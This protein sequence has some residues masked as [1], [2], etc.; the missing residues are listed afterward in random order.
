VHEPFGAHPSP[1]Q[2]YYSRDNEFF[3]AY[4]TETKTPENYGHWR[5]KWVDAVK[6]RSEY[7]N[8]LGNE[9]VDALRVKQHAYSAPADFGY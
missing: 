2:G 6:S 9:R 7:L 8:V 4:H 3:R 5:A 1:V